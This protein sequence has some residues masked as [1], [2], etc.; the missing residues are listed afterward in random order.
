M[1]GKVP[2]IVVGHL[3]DDKPD[4]KWLAVTQNDTATLLG[5]RVPFL[6]T[7]PAHRVLATSECLRFHARAF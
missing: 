4:A 1:G 2:V 6:V 5:W 3:F 7:D